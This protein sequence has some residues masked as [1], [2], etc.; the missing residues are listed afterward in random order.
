MKVSKIHIKDFHQFNDLEIDLTYPAGHEKEGKPLEKICFIGQS[1]TGK[2]KMLDIIGGLTYNDHELKRKYDFQPGNAVI[3]IV[4]FDM[5]YDRQLSIN[6]LYPYDVSYYHYGPE[7]EITYKRFLEI[8]NV[9]ISFINPNLIYYPAELKYEMSEEVLNNGNLKNKKILDFSIDKASDIW[10]IILADIQAHQEKE[11]EIRQKISRVVEDNKNDLTRI[12]EAVTTA[13]AALED[14][15][16]NNFNPIED[17]DEKC[18]NPILEPFHLRVKTKLDIK[19]KEDIGF[20]KLE[21]TNGNEIPYGLWS[22]GTKQVVLSALPLYLLKPKHTIIL[23]DEPE[24]SLYPDLQRNIINY[25]QTLA[26]DCQMFFATH[27]PIIASSFEPWEIVE[28]K[29]NSKG[30]VYQEKYY[31]GERH[32]DNYNISPNYLTYDLILSKVFD[33]KETYPAERD[34]KITEAL[35]LRNQLN[36]LKTENKLKT[37]EGE[38]ILTRY[39]K[40]ARQ[41]AWDFEPEAYDETR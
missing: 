32:V 8:E 2:T 16:K 20:I 30:H 36:K 1:G 24:R 33:M 25:Y 17:I 40:L 7:D 39:M 18:L 5:R 35:M 15:Q 14:W 31:T 10:N 22:T 3:G 9:Y 34:E 26:P 29:F 38:D 23:F 19:R 12:K 41:L 21:D 27:S 4:N 11:L 28:L 37:K 6:E 13:V